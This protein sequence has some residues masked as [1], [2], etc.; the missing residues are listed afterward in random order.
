MRG[1]IGKSM[2]ILYI[3][4]YF[5]SPRQQGGTRSYEMSQFL[6]K[7]GH[8]VTMITSGRANPEYPTQNSKQMTEYDVDGIRLLS[9][10]G[11]YNDSRQGTG[12]AAWKRMLYFHQFA[13]AAYKAGRS[14]EKPDI[15]FATHTPLMVGLSAYFLRRRF[16]VPFVFEIRDLWPEALV[17]IGVLRSPLVVGYLKRM[18]GFLYRTADHLTAASPGMKE[19]ILKYKVPDEKVTVVTNASDLKLFGKHVNGSL[20]RERLGLGDRFAVIYFGA[21]GKANGLDY[22][23]DAANEL[24]NRGNNSIALV[25]HGDGGTKPQ[26][27]DRARQEELDNVV[28]SEPVPLKSQMSEIVAACDACMTIYQSNKEVTW[29]PNKLFDALAAEKPV[30]VN[31]PG[32]L[33]EVVEENGCGYMTHPTNATTLADAIERLQADPEQAAV[34][35]RNA[36][37]VAEDVF[38]RDIQAAKL[39]NVFKQ[40]HN[41]GE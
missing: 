36:R 24:K 40:L 15:I 28:F 33:G 4:Q 29:S 39:E 12:M 18:S 7:Q 13:W 27:M 14:E 22:V 6:I 38:A 20:E 10:S 3:H 19:G 30:L 31:V 1:F 17:N 8:E 26:L 35:A 34:F 23:L 9:V 32:W 37:R 11:G 21:H 2:K 25:L 41:R 16:K 5:T